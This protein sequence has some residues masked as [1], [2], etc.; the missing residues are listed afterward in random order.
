M[1]CLCSTLKA[2]TAVNV[3]LTT[4]PALRYTRVVHS[5]GCSGIILHCFVMSFL[6]MK[7]VE[8][9]LARCTINV[10]IRRICEVLFPN[11]VHVGLSR[12]LIPIPLNARHGLGANKQ[13]AAVCPGSN[14][15]HG[16]LMYMFVL[17]CCNR[18]Q[19]FTWTVGAQ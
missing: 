5:D 10:S 12:L 19:I 9:C 2:I 8:N 3:I 15:R 17:I 14:N 4:M 1:P 13:I 6:E 7:P 16:L 11:T 18:E